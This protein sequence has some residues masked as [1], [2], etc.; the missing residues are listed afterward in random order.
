MSQPATYIPLNLRRM[1]EHLRR[2][3][4]PAA[5]LVTTLDETERRICS[6]KPS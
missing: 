3:S 4:T 6:L 2:M 1:S 5:I